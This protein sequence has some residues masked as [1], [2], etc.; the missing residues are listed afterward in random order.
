M[1]ML[2]RVSFAF[3]KIYV[4]AHSNS[5]LPFFPFLLFRGVRGFEVGSARALQ[6]ALKTRA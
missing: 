1:I 5:I 4:F 2:I 3:E 6:V